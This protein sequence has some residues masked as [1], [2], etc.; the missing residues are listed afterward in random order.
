MF[1]QCKHCN[2]KF[3]LGFG[4]GRH[5]LEA[6]D[7]DITPND[8]RHIRKKRLRSCLLPIILLGKLLRLV[9][10]GICFPFY[11]LFNWLVYEI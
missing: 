10:I 2:K 9:T 11:L 5:L 8:E 7:I 6:H 1:I 4:F 3:F